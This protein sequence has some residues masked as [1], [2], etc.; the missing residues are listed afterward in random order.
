[1]S[2]PN[3]MHLSMVICDSVIEDKLTGKKSLIGIFNNINVYTVPC[4][5]PRLNV[6][7]ALTE[8]NG[9]YKVQMRCLKV[10]DERKI[11]SIDG[12]VS[13]NE[14][15]Q[16]IE[17]NFDIAGMKFPDYGDYRFEFLTEGRLVVARK[18]RVSEINKE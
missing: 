5:H 9:Q 6:F 2:K 1:M 14:P 3:P 10:G 11:L 7:I 8:G 18:F 16:I 4:V 15:R 13:F 12:E 17:L